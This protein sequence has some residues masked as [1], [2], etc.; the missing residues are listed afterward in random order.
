MTGPSRWLAFALLS[1]AVAC[2]KTAGPVPP[3]SAVPG[4]SLPAVSASGPGPA[5]T[6]TARSIPIVFPKIDWNPL[7][8]N[9]ERGKLAQLPSYDPASIDPFQVDLRGY[10]L[11][12]LDLR[13]SLAVLRH[14]NF[15]DRTIWP[16]AEKLP[17]GFDREKI[18]AL[19]RTPGLGLARLHAEGILGT[20]V[21][22]AIIDQRLLVHH[23]EYAGRLRLY[24]ETG[25]VNGMAEMHGAAVASI[26]V[27]K[28]V[29]V[30]PEADLYFIANNLCNRGDFACLAISVRRMLEINRQLP[31]DRKIR[32]LSMS[33][34]WGPSQPGYAEIIAAVNE[35]KAAGIFVICSTES[36]I[37]P[38]EFQ[39]LGRNPDADPDAFESYG[40][41]SWWA[42]QF[43]SGKYSVDLQTLLLVPMD[44]RTTASPT[45]TDDYVFYSEGG[46]S[47]S[48]PYLAGM[49]A[50][51]AQVKPDITP[52]VFWPTALQT[53]RTIQ[54]PHGDKQY[55]FGTILDPVALID[56]LK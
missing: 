29:G 55:S 30:A 40:P 25:E 38:F 27:G 12:G 4:A 15:D 26:A 21:G 16:P 53:G 33:I 31:N 35:A 41:G 32:V 6:A 10:D 18:M 36:E 39:G 47:W 48:I 19:G 50:L 23:Q 3:S 22:I 20:K 28:T 14:A 43:F 24:E 46:R 5:P 54:I 11:S 51:A 2:S 42:D 56:A 9:W 37:Y 44:A 1:A 7:P 52:E 8:L 45:G 49:Y 13:S 34:G 17:E